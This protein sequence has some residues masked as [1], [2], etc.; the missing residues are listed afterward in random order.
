M[1]QTNLNTEGRQQDMTRPADS[2][3]I[4]VLAGGS[5]RRF[6]SDKALAYWQDTTVIEAV[7]QEAGKACRNIV[8]A[9]GEPDNYRWIGIPKISDI[10]Q[11]K[12]PIGGLYSALATCKTCWLMLLACDM[13]LVDS[14]FIRYMLNIPTRAQIIIPCIRGR[15][16][17]LHALYSRSIFPLVRSLIEMDRLSM[18]NLLDI[19]PVHVVNEREVL[20]ICG[21]TQCL[22]NFNT[23]D[24]LERLRGYVNHVK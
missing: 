18:L 15:F 13:P 21:G 2:V 20:D 10:V 22:E 8:I 14:R 1:N 17:P 4:V 3:T 5:S 7:I 11:G 12:G 9:A 6:G 16:E 23:R 24:E 19:A